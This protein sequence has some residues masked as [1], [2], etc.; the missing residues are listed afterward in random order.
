MTDLLEELSTS[1]FQRQSG[2]DY[3]FSIEPGKYAG[4]TPPQEFMNDNNISTPSDSEP[5]TDPLS[6]EEMET[7][8]SEAERLGTDISFFQAREK[9]PRQKLNDATFNLL[10]NFAKN[11]LG[12]DT[13][14]DTGEGYTTNNSI[15]LMADDLIGTKEKMGLVD[16]MLLGAVLGSEE[17]ATTAKQGYNS[18]RAYLDKLDSGEAQP[19]KFSL[20]GTGMTMDLGALKAGSDMFMGGA[21]ALINVATSAPAARGLY[22]AGRFLKNKAKDVGGKILEGARKRKDNR[23]GG[24]TL[25]TGI[26]GEDVDDAIVA[27]GDMF[28]PQ[29]DQDEL[30]FFSKALEEVKNL[31][32]K[33]GQGSQFKA[34]LLNAGV[35]PDELKWTGLDDL[36]SKKNVTKEELMEH[37]KN[38]RVQIRE[39]VLEGPDENT[40]ASLNFD[41]G[42]VDD[43]SENWMHRTEDFMDDLKRGEEFIVEQIDSGLKEKPGY[44]PAMLEALKKGEFEYTDADN[45]V[46]DFR[47]D[48]EEIA[49]N[50]AREEYLDN[51]YISYRDRDSGYE[52]YG[53][54]DVGFSINTPNGETLRLIGGDIYS[55]DEARVQ[56]ETHAMD[57]GYVTTADGQA[58][59]LD[60]TQPGGENYREILLQNDNFSGDPEYANVRVQIDK[61][62]QQEFQLR[63][64][65]GALEF[66]PV[67]N[68]EKIQAIQKQIRELNN[69]ESEIRKKLPSYSLTSFRENSHFAED[70]IIAHVRVKDRKDI[71]GNKVL[72]IEEFQSDWA[73]VGGGRKSDTMRFNSP[74]IQAN[75]AK[76]NNLES[77]KQKLSEAFN[78]KIAA[79]D[80][81][82]PTTAIKNG[83]EIRGS[84]IT[85]VT[86]K[87][88][89]LETARIL[90]KDNPGAYDAFVELKNI[91]DEI[92]NLIKATPN[93]I[94]PRG[95]LVEKTDQWTQMGLK[96]MIRYATENGYDYVAWSPGDVQVARWNNKGVGEFYDKVIPKNANAVLKKIDKKAKVEVIEM[97]INRSYRSYTLIGGQKTLAIPITDAIRSSA[98]KGQ[99]LFTPIAATALGGGLAA[100]SM[101]QE[102]Q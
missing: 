34:M 47:Y 1:R 45:N 92:N 21:E 65:Q 32:Q 36:L 37:A 73:Q 79:G 18:Y 58:R 50:I 86:L 69:Q 59:W 54:D 63:K 14:E 87:N 67:R 76:I 13:S 81:T 71:D 2:T 84:V 51:P 8:R 24:T 5:R 53:N 52:I 9:T 85:N 39:T 41:G 102:R 61:L 89:D 75:K 27:V 10:Q 42:T 100:Q 3:N 7:M 29:V 99:P 49:D 82:H 72:Y 43:F 6:E 74:E 57:Y 26:T 78:K 17:G 66:D 94:V 33:K 90:Y 28:T 60:Y 35:K 46:V 31:K 16:F 98:P 23:P 12:M 88:T 4:F 19:E 101:N 11:N 62:R 64:E 97:P 95:P 91:Y 77:K 20:P 80:Y 25:R 44:N 96:R 68:S 15:Q 83:R 56:A 40:P 93:T 38:N 70:N 48:V 55:L 30:G 22:G